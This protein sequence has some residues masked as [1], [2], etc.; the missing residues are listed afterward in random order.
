M[1]VRIRKVLIGALSASKSTSLMVGS[2][3]T[4]KGERA[5]A[6]RLLD[7]WRET[8]ARLSPDGARAFARQLNEWADWADKGNVIQQWQAIIRTATKIE[9]DAPPPQTGEGH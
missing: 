4:T 3:I 9:T 8:A 5:V 6:I 7:G 1:F 2:H